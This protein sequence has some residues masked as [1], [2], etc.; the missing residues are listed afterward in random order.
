MLSNKL[1]YNI[2]LV[3]LLLAF[4]SMCYAQATVTVTFGIQPVGPNQVFSVIVSISPSTTIKA[5]GQSF[6]FDSM[7]IFSLDSINIPVSGIPSVA[8][9][10]WGI[11]FKTTSGVVGLPTTNCQQSVIMSVATVTPGWTKLGEFYFKTSPT[12]VQSSSIRIIMSDKVGDGIYD[13]NN[14]AISHNYVY[15]LVTDIGD[16]NR[17]SLSG[18]SRNILSKVIN[19]EPFFFGY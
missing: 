6:S 7:Q 1:S 12:Y 14:V 3:L 13:A 16:W 2:F 17:Y 9:P 15:D 8:N 5:Y 19:R 10:D 11:G 4:P 18:S